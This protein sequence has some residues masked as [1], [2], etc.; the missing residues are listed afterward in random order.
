ML[1][2]T[3]CFGVTGSDAD[4]DPDRE[5]RSRDAADCAER[6]DAQ[7]LATVK[8]AV[9]QNKQRLHGLKRHGSR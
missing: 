7:K 6:C 2:L 3:R 4:R 9:A 8:Q 5:K 1:F